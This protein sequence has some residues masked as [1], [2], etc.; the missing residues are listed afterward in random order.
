MARPA[1]ARLPIR[2]DH[3]A[4]IGGLDRLRMTFSSTKHL[5]TF[6]RKGFRTG[7]GSSLHVG[8]ANELARPEGT[9]VARSGIVIIGFG[10]M[11]TGSVRAVPQSALTP[12][13]SPDR[14]FKSG[15]ALNG[16]GHHEP[17]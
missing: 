7:S 8:V 13:P 2:R 11:P 3:S 12:G 9:V 10:V 5:R 4:I 14:G 15:Q 16:H 6:W 1:S 17:R